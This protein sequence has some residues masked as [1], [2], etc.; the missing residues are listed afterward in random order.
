MIAIVSLLLVP[1]MV[2]PSFST[3]PASGYLFGRG[4]SWRETFVV[5]GGRSVAVSGRLYSENI[6]VA[7]SFTVMSCCGF[8]SNDIDFSIH[9]RD[10]G[11]RNYGIVVN[12]QV[13]DW[14]TEENEKFS[15]FFDNSWCCV[16]QP[17]GI[18]GPDL[19]HPSSHNKTVDLTVREVAPAALA[20]AAVFLHPTLIVAYGIVVAVGV[21]AIAV[22]RFRKLKSPKNNGLV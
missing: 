1:A 13:F 2:Y 16:C 6:H 11:G 18:C 21:I 12:S 8:S 9:G 4:V 10:F 17:A 22:L 15:L 14:N 19:S 5:E 3:Y 20:D 7:G